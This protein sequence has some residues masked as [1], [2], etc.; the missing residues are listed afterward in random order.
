MQIEFFKK[1]PVGQFK[2]L[3]L[4]VPEQLRHVGLH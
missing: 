1:Y 3:V 2:Q 4:K